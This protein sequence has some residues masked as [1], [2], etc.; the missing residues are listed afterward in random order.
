MD[1]GLA[2]FTCFPNALGNGTETGGDAG[3]EI[4]VEKFMYGIHGSSLILFFVSRQHIFCPGCHNNGQFGMTAMHAGAWVERVAE[5]RALPTSTISFYFS[6]AFVGDRKLFRKLKRYFHGKESSHRGK[7]LRDKLRM[8]R[9][10]DV[11]AGYSIV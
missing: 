9:R 3:Q 8:T 4:A 7:G 5:G 11:A 6:C 1:G 10:S 2:L